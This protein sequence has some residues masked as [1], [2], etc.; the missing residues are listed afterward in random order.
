MSERELLGE[1]LLKRGVIKPEQLSTA[2]EVQQRDKGL[3][4]EIL[5]RLGAVKEIDVVVA[6]VLQCNLSY[7]AINKYELDR[8]V[9]GLIPEETAKRCHLIAWEKT[10]DLVSVVMADP[11]NEPIV[12]EVKRLTRCRIAPFIATQKEIDLAIARWYAPA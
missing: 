12:D 11:L 3:I 6:L 7:I 2:L 8:D 10:G 4:G 9:V 1:I 5:V